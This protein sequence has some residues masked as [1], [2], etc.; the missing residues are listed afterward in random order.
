MATTYFIVTQKKQVSTL[1]YHPSDGSDI[2]RTKIA[3]S[4]DWSRGHFV[5]CRYNLIWFSVLPAIRQGPLC[6]QT[7]WRSGMQVSW[8]M[9]VLRLN[10]WSFGYSNE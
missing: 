1:M 8:C 4:Q 3:C 2:W 7:F 10:L 6:W 5:E 9:T